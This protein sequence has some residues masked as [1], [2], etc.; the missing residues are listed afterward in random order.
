MAWWKT[1]PGA[2]ATPGIYRSR[3]SD[4]VTNTALGAWTLGTE[5]MAG[6]PPSYVLVPPVEPPPLPV[7]EQALLALS[8]SMSHVVR[9]VDI[10]EED[11]TSLWMGDAPTS[12][13]SVSVDGTRDERRTLDLTLYNENGVLAHRPNGFWYDK[14]IKPYRGVQLSDGTKYFWPLGEFLIDKISSP[15]F[16]PIVKVSGRDYAKKLVEDEFQVATAFVQGTPIEQVVETILVNG[17]ISKYVLP[18]TGLALAKEFLFKAETT[19][20]K[21]LT[22]IL[23]AYGFEGYFDAQGVFI[24]RPYQDPAGRTTT[25]TFQTG[26]AGN[27][28]TYEKTASSTNLYNA[29]TVT[30]QTSDPNVLPVYGIAENHDPYSP[31]SIENLRRKRTLFW[32]SPLITMQ[33]QAQAI[34]ERLLTVAATDTFVVNLA[35]LVFPFLEAMDVVDFADPDQQPGE[36]KRFLLTDFNIPLGLSTMDANAKRITI[37]T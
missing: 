31:A 35:A 2:Q 12:E 16:P 25:F 17:G 30:S 32:S 14:I 13:G 37:I 36:P 11:G 8:A 15:N 3:A 29:I 21:A 28:S 6:T 24:M 22:D 10:F 23:T 19:R 27:L 9:R 7:L 20:W 18:S 33:W 4:N 1:K 34:A 5:P 26:Q